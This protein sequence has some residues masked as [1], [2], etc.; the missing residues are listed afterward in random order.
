MRSPWALAIACAGEWAVPSPQPMQPISEPSA[1]P[2]SHFA[3]CSGLPASSSASVASSVAMNGTGASAAADLL[4][5]HAGLVGA[6][7]EAAERLRYPHRGP[8]KLDDLSPQHRIVR[9]VA[10]HLGAR[11]LRPGL[12]VEEPPRLFAQRL[13]I[14]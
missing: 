10:V 1:N 5:Q 8:A 12:L 14:V 6:E 2:P 13:G 3:C 4:R 11:R 9:R 7:P